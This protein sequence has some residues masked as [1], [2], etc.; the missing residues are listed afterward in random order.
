M[1]YTHRGYESQ[2][3]YDDRRKKLGMTRCLFS[4][5][6]D[7]LSWPYSASDVVD[8]RGQVSGASPSRRTCQLSGLLP[9]AGGTA[10]SRAPPLNWI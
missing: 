8:N 1:Q 7:P 10:S 4:A 5:P 3:S 6:L 2:R 9:A